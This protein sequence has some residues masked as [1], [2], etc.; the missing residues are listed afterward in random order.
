[1][2]SIE[3]KFGELKEASSSTLK[4]S[5][6]HYLYVQI[7]DTR[8]DNVWVH[9]YIDDAFREQIGTICHY[10]MIRCKKHWV[11][12]AFKNENGL[13]E[14]V[15]KIEFLEVL[16]RTLNLIPTMIITAIILTFVLSM[17]ISIAV[18]ALTSRTS[19]NL[20][21][22]EFILAMVISIY[23]VVHIS[24]LSKATPRAIS[25]TINE[26]SLVFD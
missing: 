23:F 14:K 20:Q 4:G 8:Y 3:E 7:G 15:P 21:E 1:M 11:L 26:A 2:Y 24:I 13:V 16:S 12:C 19:V 5:N 22:W 25:K 17:V 18:S 6:Y 10:S 9:E